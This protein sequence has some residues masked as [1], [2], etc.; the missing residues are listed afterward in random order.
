MCI[1]GKNVTVKEGVVL[2]GV[3]CCPHKVIERSR[4]NKEVIM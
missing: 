3:L 2:R 4:W 1:F